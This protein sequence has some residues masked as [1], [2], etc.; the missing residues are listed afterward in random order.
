MRSRGESR[1]IAISR[2][3]DA[4]PG[5][6]SALAYCK[7]FVKHA[8]SCRNITCEFLITA[9]LRERIGCVCFDASFVTT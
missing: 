9:S 2:I 6:T 4:N 7:K 3:Y 8:K 5:L 1:R